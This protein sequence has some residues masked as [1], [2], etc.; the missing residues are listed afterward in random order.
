MNLVI[1]TLFAVLAVAS[2]AEEQTNISWSKVKSVI[3][4]YIPN[5]SRRVYGGSPAKKTQFPYQAG[6]ILSKSKVDHLC[7]GALISSTRVL[8]AAHC[9]DGVE[10]VHV[11]LGARIL[12]LDEPTQVRFDIPLKEI[13][14]HPQFDHHKLK[15]DIAIIKLPSAVTFNDYVSP[16]TLP[17]R[18]NDYLDDTGIISGWGH[19][20]NSQ[21]DSLVLRYGYLKIMKCSERIRFITDSTMCATG[22]GKIDGCNG[23]SGG[24]LAVQ[25]YGNAILVG[26]QSFVLETGCGQGTGF[27]RVTSFIPWIKSNM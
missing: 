20:D 24:P 13:V 27:A 6:L 18:T 25:S 15:N 22:Q 11:V 26:I 7:G 3:E 17:E 21:K 12:D 8:T 2:L 23:D 9:L 14:L 10:S 4:H 5:E 1:A 19:F 16:I